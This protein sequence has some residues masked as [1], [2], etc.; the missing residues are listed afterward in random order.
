MANWDILKTAVSELI[1]TNGN[2]EITGQVLQTVL[3]SIITN[4][5]E[6]A[7]FAGIAT[8]DTN[9]GTPDGPVFYLTAT[10]GTYPNFNG[11]EV[12]DGEAVILLWDDSVWSKKATGFATREKLSELGLNIGGTQKSCLTETIIGSLKGILECDIYIQD[13]YL[14]AYNEYNV[15]IIGWSSSSKKVIF[16][17]LLKNAN[18]TK[19]ITFDLEENIESLESLP[20]GI[21]EYNT[22]S[23]TGDNF[24]HVVLNYNIIGNTFDPKALFVPRAYSQYVPPISTDELEVSING[25][26]DNIEPYNV[27]SGAIKIDGTI[28]TLSGGYNVYTYNVTEGES[29]QLFNETA[30]VGTVKRLSIAAYN[31][32]EELVEVISEWPTTDTLGTDN[33]QRFIS[34]YVV[35]KGVSIIKMGNLNKTSQYVKRIIKEGLNHKVAALEQ[36]I[37]NIEDSNVEGMGSVVRKM[38]NPQ[39]SIQKESLKILHIGNSFMNGATLFLNDLIAAAGIDVSDMCLYRCFRGGGSFK[40][41]V[42]CWHDRDTS[43]YSIDR[44]IGG[45]TQDISGSTNAQNGEALRNT[46]KNNEWDYIILQQASAYAND[47]K[48]WETTSNGGYLKE[49]IRIIKVCQ[50]KATIGFCMVHSSP[51]D[52]SNI[53]VGFDNIAESTRWFM[54]NYGVDFV[55]PYG[56]AIQNIRMSDVSQ[57]ASH[58]LCKDNHHLAKGVG[59][60]VANAAYFQAVIAPRYGVSVLG[61]SFRYEVSDTDLSS[62]TYPSE[63]ISVTDENAARCQ[64]AAILACCDMWNVVNPDSIVL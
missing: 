9:P 64:M 31:E 55:I 8:L 26:I 43:E 57:S 10:T 29:Y 48:E 3:N 21:K 63:C 46:I 42:D 1:N 40:T 16:R 54:T 12:L 41:W 14:E 38:Y 17:L 59:N 2:Q 20:N 62:S 27:V 47:Y 44:C 50:P 5:G 30:N 19:N 24:I 52:N 34:N 49:L 13:D 37:S 35:P 33:L 18:G 39:N 45:I 28:V 58:G 32:E 36:R 22:R 6:N 56:T 60:Y 61:N 23:R 25:N 11:L 15:D 4:V 7:A 53:S 51:R